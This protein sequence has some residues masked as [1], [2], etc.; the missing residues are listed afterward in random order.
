MTPTVR[1]HPSSAS[2]H[3]AY[4]ETSNSV[5]ISQRHK[6]SDNQDKRQES[7]DQTHCRGLALHDNCLVGASGPPTCLHHSNPT[8]NIGAGSKNGN[9]RRPRG[10]IQGEIPLPIRPSW[11]FDDGFELTGRVE[12]PTVSD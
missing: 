10:F 7:R 1:A 4:L 12:V 2:R 11:A 5:A 3:E 9:G 6:V 8:L